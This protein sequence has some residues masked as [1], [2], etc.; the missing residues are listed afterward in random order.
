MRAV[1]AF[2]CES[3]ARVYYIQKSE[4][5]A[6]VSYFAQS[7]PETLTLSLSW[8]EESAR[9]ARARGERVLFPRSLLPSFR[10]EVNFFIARAP[11]VKDAFDALII[12]IVGGPPAVETSSPLSVK[13]II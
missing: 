8:F 7:S 5:G 11:G 1:H 6:S 10:F 2:E 9:D 12:L 13:C 4:R 3:R